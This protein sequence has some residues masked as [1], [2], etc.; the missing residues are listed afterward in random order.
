MSYFAVMG[1][2]TG[3]MNTV[4]AVDDETT[5]GRMRHTVGWHSLVS[6][7]LYSGNPEAV[8]YLINNGFMTD[9]SEFDP[10][11]GTTFT[12]QIDYKTIEFLFKDRTT[13]RT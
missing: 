3:L 12:D 4:L 5:L 11:I 8:S 7:A 9:K 6:Y 1:N 10:H 13:T 2:V